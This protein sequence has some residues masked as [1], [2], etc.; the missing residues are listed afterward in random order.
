M[1]ANIVDGKSLIRTTKPNNLTKQNK[2]NFC[3]G[4]LGRC[5]C[6]DCNEFAMSTGSIGKVVQPKCVKTETCK[7][8]MPKKASV[9]EKEL[10]R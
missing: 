3:L 8:L 4:L 9:D 10:R 7:S 2:S 5:L 6:S 1:S